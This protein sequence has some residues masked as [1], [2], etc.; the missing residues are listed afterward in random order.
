MGF[1]GVFGGV[2]WR[3]L[4]L[5]VRANGD[6]PRDDWRA[7]TAELICVLLLYAGEGG[8]LYDTMRAPVTPVEQLK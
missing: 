7:C 1:A 2:G 6:T 5:Q 4:A 3:F 8:L